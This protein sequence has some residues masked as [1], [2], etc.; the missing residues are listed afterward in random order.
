M[1]YVSTLGGSSHS[2]L[3]VCQGLHREWGLSIALAF[4]AYY[5]GELCSVSDI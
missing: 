5:E 2:F 1:A 4:F 3:S